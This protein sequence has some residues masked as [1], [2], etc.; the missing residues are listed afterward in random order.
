L[1]PDEQDGSAPAS[2][3]LQELVGALDAGE[4]LLEVD[5]VDAGAFSEDE[6]PHLRVPPASLVAEVDASLQQFPSRDD[7]HVLPPL[8]VSSSSRLTR[9][10]A[11]ASGAGTPEGILGRAYSLPIQRKRPASLPATLSRRRLDRSAGRVGSWG[12]RA[13]WTI[14][15][16]RG[17][18]PATALIGRS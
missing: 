15:A 1:G 16:L 6:P 13:G 17:R 10:P 14:S 5:D 9:P 11:P 3:A 4:R 12:G 7:R 18:L 2:D 8:L